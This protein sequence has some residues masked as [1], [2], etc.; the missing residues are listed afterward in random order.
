LKNATR[1]S[2]DILTHAAQD[3]AQDA[4]GD[5]ANTF[6]NE[7][8]IDQLQ[9][10]FRLFSDIESDNLLPGTQPFTPD[11]VELHPSNTKTE[12]NKYQRV[13]L[14]PNMHIGVHYP[15]IAEEY[16]TPWNCNVLIDENKHR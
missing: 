5:T 2:E 4:A 10:K 9:E 16:G 12:N 14:R 13:Q 1:I 11:F 15:D 6:A 8:E 7:D 3:A